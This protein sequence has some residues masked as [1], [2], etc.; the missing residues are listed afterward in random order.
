M[1]ELW[2][3]QVF[4]WKII[5]FISVYMLPYVLPSLI[6]VTWFNILSGTIFICFMFYNLSQG[7]HS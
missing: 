2:Q 5:P 4:A 3:I 1:R 7:K 6:R